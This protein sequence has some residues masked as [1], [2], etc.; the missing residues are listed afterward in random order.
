MSSAFRLSIISHLAA[1]VAGALEATAYPTIHSASPQSLADYVSAICA[2][3]FGSAP[4]AE[5]LYLA[6][7][8]SATTKMMIDM[9][10]RLSGVVDADFV[11]MT[12]PHIRRDGYR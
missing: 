11:A 10:V 4:A 6:E 3:S 5:A 12:G 9:G 1:I 7:K 2:K 8:V